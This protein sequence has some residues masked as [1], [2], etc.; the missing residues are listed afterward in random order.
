MQACMHRSLPPTIKYHSILIESKPN[1]LSHLNVLRVALLWSQLSLAMLAMDRHLFRTHRG[2]LCYRNAR[3]FPS[4]S[5]TSLQRARVFLWIGP[6]EQP[7]PRS[8]QFSP[9]RLVQIV[10]RWQQ[11][12]IWGVQSYDIFPDKKRSSYIFSPGRSPVNSI[13]MSR[14]TSSPESRIK[15]RARSKMRTDSPISSIKISLPCASTAACSN[16]CTA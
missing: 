15:S 14:S 3:W 4:I 10:P 8:P 16:S 12:E 1:Q 7:R 9:N 13:S 2:G 11:C 5:G 6:P